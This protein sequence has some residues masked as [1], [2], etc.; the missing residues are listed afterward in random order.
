MNIKDLLKIANKYKL[1]VIEDAAE[2]LGS[3][4]K[5]IHVGNFGDIGILSFNGNKVITTGGGGMLLIKSNNIAKKA[6]HLATS[7]K[8]LHKWEYFPIKH[9]DTNTI[10]SNKFISKSRNIHDFI[11]VHWIQQILFWNNHFTTSLIICFF[12]AVFCFT[13]FVG[14]FI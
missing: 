14:V 12:Y 5:N 10:V 3:Y 1:K 8:K 2:A 4:Y 11:V 9:K 7:A 13:A 6:K